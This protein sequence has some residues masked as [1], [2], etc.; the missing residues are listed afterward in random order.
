[1]KW[2]GSVLIYHC[3]LKLK[4]QHKEPIMT[5]VKENSLEA[6]TIASEALSTETLADVSTS[7]QNAV[8]GLTEAVQAIVDPL[9]TQLLSLTEETE[10]NVEVT[11]SKGDL[12]QLVKEVL[13]VASLGGDIAPKH[14]PRLS[15]HPKTIKMTLPVASADTYIQGEITGE[16]VEGEDYNTFVIS[17]VDPLVFIREVIIA[18]QRGGIV[19]PGKTKFTS[20]VYSTHILVKNLLQTGP[21]I[22]QLGKQII[23]TKEQLKAYN[24]FDLKLIGAKYG[25]SHR[26]K[27]N[28]VK[29]ILDKQEEITNV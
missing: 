23:Y 8:N 3:N 24:L 26:G 15:Q 21:H 2:G 5:D 28:L 9:P 10:L 13:I 29:L 25:V 18:G 19:K 11:I 7:E 20:S 16:E 22:S 12:S 14:L 4:Q 27:D 6:P 1:M 17:S